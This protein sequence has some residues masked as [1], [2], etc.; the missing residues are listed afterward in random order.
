MNT[1][2][3]LL[4]QIGRLGY[5][6]AIARDHVEELNQATGERFIVRSADVYSA[7]V[8][9]AVQVGFELDD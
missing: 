9:L 2:R 5:R 3:S 7:A 4:E 1:I 6:V 8:E